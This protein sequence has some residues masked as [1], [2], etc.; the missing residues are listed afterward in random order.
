M[1][2]FPVALLGMFLIAGGFTSRSGGQDQPPSRSTT[3]PRMP[4]QPSPQR[5]PLDITAAPD[6]ERPSDTAQE[7]ARLQTEERRKK[8]AADTDRLVELA[9][10]LNAQ[11]KQSN[12]GTLSADQIKKLDAIEKLAHG[13]KERMKG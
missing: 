11:M 9:R 7:V 5:D 4:K 8:L 3:R 10:D 12:G 2:A 6:I 13:V 1:T